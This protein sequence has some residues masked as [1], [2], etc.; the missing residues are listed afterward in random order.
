MKELK[1]KK[2]TPL[3]NYVILTADRYTA[4]ELADMYGG[5]VPAGMTD[6]LKPYQKIV[7]ISPRSSMVNILE[8]DML[9]L[10]NIDRYGRSMQK[11]NSIKASMDEHYDNHVIYDVPIIELDGKECLKLGDND[12][13]FIIEDYEFVTIKK[14]STIEVPDKKILVN[15]DPKILLN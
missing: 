6:Q 14:P 1:I 8:P 7:S 3:L 13:E 5:I 4:D 10:I 15:K 12:I 11:K 2:G 9:V